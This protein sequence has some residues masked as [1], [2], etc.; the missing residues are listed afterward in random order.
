MKDFML[1]FIGTDYGALG[2]SPEEMQGRMGKWFAWNQKMMDAGQVETGHALDST[3]VRQ[4]SGPARTVT[5][6]AGSEVKELIGGYVSGLNACQFCY[7]IHSTLADRFGVPEAQLKALL[8]D[9][10]TA[11]VDEKL[12][13][14][15][16]YVQKVTLTPSSSHPVE[17]LFFKRHARSLK[18]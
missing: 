12:K 1:I 2:L 14:L 6:R 8:E 15:F 4:V 17:T 10:D 16:H 9:I 18:R 7:S 13:P 3:K 11:P 5:D